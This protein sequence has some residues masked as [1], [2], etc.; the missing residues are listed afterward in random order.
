MYSPIIPTKKSIND[1]ENNNP[2]T[3]GAI[4]KVKLFQLNKLI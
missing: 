4:P 1:I 3:N 2:T